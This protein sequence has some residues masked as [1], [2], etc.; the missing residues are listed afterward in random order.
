[1]GASYLAAAR[2]S[3]LEAR[4]ADA[5]LFE[6]NTRRIMCQSLFARGSQFPFAEPHLCR[7]R[8]VTRFGSRRHDDDDCDLITTTTSADSDATSTTSTTSTA[9]DDDND[10]VFPHPVE[11]LLV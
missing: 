11:V 9:S 7:F 10:D 6:K 1:M 5:V 3:R 8:D 4:G 2:H